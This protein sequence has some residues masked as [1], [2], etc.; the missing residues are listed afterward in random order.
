MTRSFVRLRARSLCFLLLSLSLFPLP[1][2][3]FSS[4]L[5]P[6]SHRDT[7]MAICAC[8]L[9]R[10]NE[11]R[12]IDERASEQT[13]PF[14]SFFLVYSVR[15][16][17]VCMH[18]FA[19]SGFFSPV[20]FSYSLS[21][22][23]SP[24]ATM[25]VQKIQYFK[26]AAIVVIVDV[27]AILLSI[28]H[29]QMSESEREKDGEYQVIGQG[30]IYITTLFLSL[31]LSTFTFII[32]PRGKERKEKKERNRERESKIQRRIHTPSIHNIYISIYIYIM[33]RN[34]YK[35]LF[36]LA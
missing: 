11:S 13:A 22:F 26:L 31:V 12:T 28:I 27:D 21:F 30:R 4:M 18:T 32:R 29:S 7:Y 3:P 2:P 23:F 20:F 1:S 35:T 5:R 33:M 24:T 36:N 16:S 8:A 34:L 19:F 10:K 6:A 14:F 17:C 25:N 15:V 9:A